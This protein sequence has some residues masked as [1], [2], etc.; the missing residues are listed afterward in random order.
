MNAIGLVAA[1]A[2]AAVGPPLQH[3]PPAG[4]WRLL[5]AGAVVLT[6]E[7][8]FAYDWRQHRL[9]LRAGV[10]QTLFGRLAG[11]LVRGCPFVVLADGQ[12]CYEGILTTSV[13]SA[14][15]SGVVIDLSP[16]DGSDNELC[17]TLGYPDEHYFRGVDPRSDERVRRALG[18]RVR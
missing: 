3:G 6:E 8:V 15:F 1:L 5:A 10:R 13:S 18:D 2:V 17:I 4:G 14:V 12:R 9:T 7:D 16:P 11:Q